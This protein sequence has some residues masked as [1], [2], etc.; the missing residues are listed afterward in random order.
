LAKADRLVAATADQWDAD[1]EIFTTPEEM[2]T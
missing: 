2:T 1:P